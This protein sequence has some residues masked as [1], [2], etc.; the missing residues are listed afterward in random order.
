MIA[1]MQFLVKVLASAINKRRKIFI[2]EIL[3]VCG[4]V[5]SYFYRNMALLLRQSHVLSY[6]I[7][8]YMYMCIAIYTYLI[9]YLDSTHALCH[10]KGIN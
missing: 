9:T 7:Y 4:Y 5:K 2:Q 8:T 6:G 3:F 10:I 1:N